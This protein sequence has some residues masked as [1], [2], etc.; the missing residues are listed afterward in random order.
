M[1]LTLFFVKKRRCAI[2]HDLGNRRIIQ[3]VL[4]GSQ[5][6][7]RC[8]HAIDKRWVHIAQN[9]IEFVAE[10]NILCADTQ[11]FL[12]ASGV[13]GCEHARDR[14]ET[15]ACDQ[16]FLQALFDLY[17]MR[18][19]HN[20]PFCVRRRRSRKHTMRTLRLCVLSVLNTR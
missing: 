13:I 19:K 18:I 5:S 8:T 20:R 6:N 10:Q 1:E 4:N 2:D 17:D 12:D 9:I 16:C 11:F 15:E 14:R 3:K 7:N